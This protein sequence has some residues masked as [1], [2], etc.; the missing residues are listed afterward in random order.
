M[1]DPRETVG[2][3]FERDLFLEARNK[4]WLLMAELANRIQPGITEAQSHEL[5]EIVF[6]EFGVEKKWHKNRIRFGEST[7][8]LY[9]DPGDPNLILKEDDILIID[10]GPV[11]DAH[12]ADTGR[13]YV[14]GQDPEKLRCAQDCETIFNRVQDHWQKG[15]VNG[16]ELYAFAE[17]TALEMGWLLNLGMDGHRISEFPHAFHHKGSLI[18]F[19][20]VPSSE[21]WVLEIQIRHPKLPYGAFFE[22]LL[23]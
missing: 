1:L 8:G 20:N 7:L 15:R 14:V 19:D 22:D 11:F 5:C 9:N 10:I 3:S 17:K 16:P 12:E 2:L 13:T 23:V 4:A 21:R 18:E 6:K